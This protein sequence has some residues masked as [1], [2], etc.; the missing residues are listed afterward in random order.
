MNPRIWTYILL[1]FLLFACSIV[2]GEKDG[3]TDSGC[4]Y[5]DSERIGWVKTFGGDRH[6]QADRVLIA[7]NGDII[8]AGT[9]TGKVDFDPGPGED[10]HTATEDKIL[11]FISRYSSDGDYIW[12]K[13][14]VGKIFDLAIGLGLQSDGS[15]IIGGTFF[16]TADFDP[17][18]GKEELDS[19]V[20]GNVFVLKLTENG[21][22]VWIY[23]VGGDDAEVFTTLSVSPSGFIYFGGW[24][25][26]DIVFP[27][28]TGDEVHPREGGGMSPDA[29]VAKL[30]SEGELVWSRTIGGISKDASWD[31][32]AS[33]DDSLIW[34]GEFGDTLDFD[35]GD[36]TDEYT[37]SS[38]DI[39]LIRLDPDGNYEW[40]KHILGS[41]IDF[42]RSV[43]LDNEDNIYISIA[44]SGEIDYDI[45]DN[46]INSKNCFNRKCFS[47]VKYSLDGFFQWSNTYET[48]GNLYIPDS[49]YLDNKLII[50][51]YYYGLTD[52]NPGPGEDLHGM[53]NDSSFNTFILEVDHKGDTK[54]A[55]TIGGTGTCI[56]H[57]IAS[58]GNNYLYIAGYFDREVDFDP[59]ECNDFQKGGD[60]G[61]RD[62]F[63]LRLTSQG[64]YYP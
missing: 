40:G 31:V 4:P 49:I 11:L 50:L 64:K 6:V 63:L 35:P 59:G 21:E 12:T 39:F 27:S 46:G 56:G 33:H 14:I 10:T 28:S 45:Q 41:G 30:S 36:D 34:L 23:T 58:S 8:I 1:W 38:N 42:S 43:V 19:D 7:S 29:F 3:G 51:G 44:H 26:Q 54:W 62:A 22:Y 2:T 13:F 9:F 5:P 53:D 24:Y 37:P 55:V 17:G 60:S 32:T 52:F 61:D 15:I 48:T 47:F 16:G 18:A 25:T 20:D 57:G